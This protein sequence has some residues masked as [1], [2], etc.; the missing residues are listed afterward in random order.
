MVHSV[1]IKKRFNHPIEKVWKFITDGEY[2]SKWFLPVRE[3]EL[4]QDGK[5]HLD[6]DSSESCEGGG[7]IGTVLEV[8]EN[9]KFVH[10]FKTSDITEFTEVTWLLESTDDGGTYLTVIHKGNDKLKDFVKTIE[11]VDSGWM[12]HLTNLTKL[13]NGQIEESC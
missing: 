4:K 6:T 9:K 12:Y 7:I 2:I 1:Y 13:I 5:Y 10:T 11:S 3:L 8:V